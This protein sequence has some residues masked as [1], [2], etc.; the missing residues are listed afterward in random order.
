MTLKKK[1]LI[2]SLLF[3]LVFTLL[4]VIASL[5]D[6]EISN[7]LAGGGFRAGAYYST[8]VFGRIFE[9]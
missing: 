6:L 4:L 9:Y 8:N 5:F 1:Y 7:I 2:G 3:V